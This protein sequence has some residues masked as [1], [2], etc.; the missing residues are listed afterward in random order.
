MT[1]GDELQNYCAA[2]DG[3]TMT[4]G[5][6]DCSTWPAQWVEKRLEVSIP[7][8]PYESE[9][10]AH[11]IIE[12]A[13]GLENVWGPILASF[14]VAEAHDGVPE[15]GDIGVVRLNDG[16]HVGCIFAHGGVACF[17]TERGVRMF[18]VRP[19]AIVAVWR[20]G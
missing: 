16:R 18:G 19:K 8:P 2:Y 7:L 11:E 17:R 1:I 15:I 10:G 4:W 14:G 12:A 5:K 13:G 9:D 6:D 3:V 20:I